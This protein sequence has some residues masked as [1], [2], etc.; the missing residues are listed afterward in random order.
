MWLIYK[1]LQ[2]YR[3]FLSN[4]F[5]DHIILEDLWTL[6]FTAATH[7]LTSSYPWF[8]LKLNICCLYT[9]IQSKKIFLVR[10]VSDIQTK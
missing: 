1:F 3:F 6:L 4:H 9:V 8:N 2:K 10:G 7:L 5:V